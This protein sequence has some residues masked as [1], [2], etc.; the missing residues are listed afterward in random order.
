MTCVAAQ[1]TLRIST[2]IVAGAKRNEGQ[3]TQERGVNEGGGKGGKSKRATQCH[4]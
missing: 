3:G 1:K 2:E 4:S